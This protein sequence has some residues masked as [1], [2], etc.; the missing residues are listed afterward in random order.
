MLNG[1]KLYV[2]ENGVTREYTD[3]EYTQATVD[4]QTQ[5]S[6]LQNVVR[7]QRNTLLAKSD[8]TQAADIPFSSEQKAEWV[9]Y[10][11]ALRDLPSQSGFPT[12]VVFPT[13][14]K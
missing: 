14:P 12:N 13:E 1:E 2:S 9:T 4:A 6:G 5:L 3:A 10:R 11:Q 8:W 7:N